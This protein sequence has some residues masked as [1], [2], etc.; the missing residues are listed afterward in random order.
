[1]EVLGPFSFHDGPESFDGNELAAVGGQEILLEVFGVNLVQLLRVVDPQV[2]QDYHHSPNL[3]LGLHGL[4]E[5]HEEVG[6][7]VLNKD[8]EV[9]EASHS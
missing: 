7:V 9:H 6:A 2:V 1:M 8:L 3:A 5:I 4:H